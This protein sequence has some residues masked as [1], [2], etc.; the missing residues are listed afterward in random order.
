MSLLCKELNREG[1]C[2][3]VERVL[4]CYYAL[5]VYMKKTT[6]IIFR[7]TQAEKHYIDGAARQLKMDT[8]TLV[9]SSVEYYLR[10][11]HGVAFD[12]LWR[13]MSKVL[14]KI[15]NDRVPEADVE[16]MRG[17]L[18]E[19][20]VAEMETLAHPI[21]VSDESF[22]GMIASRVQPV[23]PATVGA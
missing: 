22:Y 4:A 7:T 19:M 12:A 10:A 6:Q 15:H 21:L 13:R 20:T 11:K 8:S 14:A 1:G 18:S 23:A 17:V 5:R 9:R 3:F 16:A 2:A